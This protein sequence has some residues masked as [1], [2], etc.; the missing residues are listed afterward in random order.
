MDLMFSKCFRR[1][2]SQLR[3]KYELGQDHVHDG[4]SIDVSMSKCESEVKYCEKCLGKYNVAEDSLRCDSCI[5]KRNS[6]FCGN[7]QKQM[8]VKVLIFIKEL[9]ENLND[10][11]S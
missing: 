7:C 4:D 10:L 1:V 8:K 3:N 11:Q 5:A 9:Y 6:N 2:I